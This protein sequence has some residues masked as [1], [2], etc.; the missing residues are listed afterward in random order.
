M[1]FGRLAGLCRFGFVAQMPRANERGGCR[2]GTKTNNQ[3]VDVPNG[4]RDEVVSLEK[5]F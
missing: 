3:Q 4:R 5:Y 2:Q 1:D